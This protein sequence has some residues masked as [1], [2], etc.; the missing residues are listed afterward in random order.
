[1]NCPFCD[2]K[3]TKVIDSRLV[4]S[5]SQVRRRRECM[6]CNE[7]YTTFE[8]PELRYPLLVKREGRKVHFNEQNL[9]GGI[10]RALEKRPVSVDL[11]EKSISLIK[12]K[13]KTCG[14]K[15]IS[16]ALIGE[17]VMQELRHLDDVAYIR[18]ASVYRAFQD[19]S[20]FNNEIDKLKKKK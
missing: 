15:E 4:E 8:T 9:R 12:H 18:F 20:D 14:A 10:L 1:M 6:V 16:T 11:I 19:T 2:D 17:W 3:D 13:L 5:G 7:R